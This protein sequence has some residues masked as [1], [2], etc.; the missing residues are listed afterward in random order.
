MY[1]R[2]E[3]RVSVLTRLPEKPRM[4]TFTH[5]DESDPG[6]L[7]VH[8]LAGISHRGQFFPEHCMV[9]T[10]RDAIAVDEQIIRERVVVSAFPK[11][12]TSGEHRSH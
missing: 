1:L 7:R 2:A 9:L 11:L 10:L 5:D 4:M 12:Q 6:L 3:R 8:D